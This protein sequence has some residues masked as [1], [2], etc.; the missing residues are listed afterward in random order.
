MQPRTILF[1][2]SQGASRKKGE[3]GIEAVQGKDRHLHING[4]R[5]LEQCGDKGKAAITAIKYSALDRVMF[6][7]FKTTPNHFGYG[8]IGQVSALES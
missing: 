7:S 8:L 6:F 3:Y 5:T 2:A 1:S 4:E